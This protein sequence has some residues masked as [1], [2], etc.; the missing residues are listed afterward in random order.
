[1]FLFFVCSVSSSSQRY[2]DYEDA[3]GGEEDFGVPYSVGSR[4]DRCNTE[5]DVRLICSKIILE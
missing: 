3:A 4:E 2:Y 1:M 5:P